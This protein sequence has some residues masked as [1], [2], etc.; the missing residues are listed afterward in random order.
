MK[1][2]IISLI[3][4]VFTISAILSLASCEKETAFD[5]LDSKGYT[6]SVKFEA[7]GGDIKGSKSNLL[8]AFNPKDF[9]VNEDGKIEIQLLAPDDERR[10]ESN[11]LTFSKPGESFVGWYKER[12]PVNGVDGKDGYTY[13]GLWN[14]ETDRLV[15][16]PNGD[17]TSAENQLTLYAAWVP[18]FTFN[19][20]TK[21]E[22]GKSVL[23]ETVDAF[24]LDLPVWED[25]E[26]RIDMG[27]IGTRKGYTFDKA[28][29]DE[30]CTDPIDVETLRGKINMEN[31]TLENKVINLY[32]TWLSGTHIYIYTEQHMRLVTSDAVCHLMNDL[33]FENS[34][35]TLNSLKFGGIFYGNGHKISNVTLETT[36]ANTSNGMFADITSSA[37]FKDVSFENISHTVNVG[38]VKADNSFGLFAGKV[39]SD[40][41]F[42]NVSISGE[43]LFGTDCNNLANYENIS[44]GI[45]VFASN[46]TPIGIDVSNINVD[47]VDKENSDFTISES[48]NG[49]ITLV[50]NNKD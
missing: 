17:Y 18:K 3:M 6:I 41:V 45:G 36:F 9:E 22:D 47:I 24:K 28:Y 34:T 8:N 27:D 11:K 40:A 49:E 29:F 46:G 20:Y 1:T 12:I 48:T 30:D 38:R 7:N 25:G 19:V 10:G 31:G 39:A 13:S 43:L 4:A 32:T 5:K 15:L 2:K 26:P 37:K 35:W 42:D 33:D 14:F 21:D 44:Y 50:F 23:L 16:D